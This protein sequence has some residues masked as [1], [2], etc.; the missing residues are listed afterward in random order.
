M[1]NLT[2]RK[3]SL[4]TSFEEEKRNENTVWS[5]PISHPSYIFQGHIKSCQSLRWI[6][7]N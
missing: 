4:I 7:E 1:V 6:L 2:L 3:I 5:L